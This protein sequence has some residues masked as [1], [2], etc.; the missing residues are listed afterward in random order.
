MLKEQVI[1]KHKEEY[2]KNPEVL[3]SAPAIVSLLGEHT[4][5]SE[6][7][8]LSY[9]LNQRVYVAISLSSDYNIK[10][11]SLDY[12]EKK[13]I[14][15]YNLKN[16]PSDKWFNYIKGVL[17]SYINLGFSLK[18][19]DITI[20]GDIWQNMGIASSSALVIALLS[21]INEILKLNI[22]SNQII[23]MAY[24]VESNFLDKN[25][26]ESDY[27]CIM[28]AKKDNLLLLDLKDYQYNYIPFKLD[29]RF[30]LINSKIMCS[31]EKEDISYRKETCKKVAKLEKKT[32]RELS[33]I[34]INNSRDLTLEEK[35]I[36]LHIVNE[37]KKLNDILVLL[38][39][40]EFKAFGKILFESHESLRDSYEISCPELDWI[41][42]RSIS[43][44]GIYG[45]RMTGTGF[46]GCVLVFS[47]D[48]DLE[49]LKENLKEYERI[50]SFDLKILKIKVSEGLKIHKIND[51]KK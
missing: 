30:F 10:C 26:R 22:A 24:Q 15:I 31:I 1:Q 41:V 51:K 9:A 46:G 5:Y 2:K 29:Q 47:E 38:E 23:K 11:N 4:E 36:C 35:R 37:L 34:N 39:K 12:K 43:S 17:F 44:K 6:G 20:Q 27:I 45:A 14:S 19:L 42:K 32:L 25:T 3:I 49:D 18:G 28:H 33:Q 48:N 8:V 50:F 7:I 21:G 16:K 13:K 40:N